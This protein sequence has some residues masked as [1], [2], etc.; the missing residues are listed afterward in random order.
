MEISQPAVCQLIIRFLYGGPPVL[1]CLHQLLPGA[2]R[3]PQAVTQ[4]GLGEKHQSFQVNFLLYKGWRPLAES[5]G[6]QEHV[7]AGVVLSSQGVAVR[8]ILL[9][10]LVIEVANPLVALDTSVCQRARTADAV[11]LVIL[12]TRMLCDPVLDW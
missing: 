11:F 1:D 4:V 2:E 10:L 9:L 6:C 3:H 7:E 5:Y 12:L 8:Q